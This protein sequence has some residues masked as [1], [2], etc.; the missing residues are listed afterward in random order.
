MKS[1][2]YFDRRTNSEIVSFDKYYIFMDVNEF[3]DANYNRSGGLLMCN[4]AEILRDKNGNYQMTCNILTPY[5]LELIRA[6]KDNTDKLVLILH[7]MEITGEDDKNYFDMIVKV[8]GLENKIQ[9]V[10]QYLL[11]DSQLKTN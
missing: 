8:L 7:I 4:R 5:S 11:D 1:C 10:E 6:V 3:A 2:V 9:K